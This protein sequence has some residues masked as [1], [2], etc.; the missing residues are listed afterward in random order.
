MTTYR[1]DA[2]A[3]CMIVLDEKTGRWK[4][5]RKTKDRVCAPSVM[6]DIKPFVARATEKPVEITSRSQLARYERANN[7]RQ[8]GDFKPGEVIAKR[9]KKLT[10]EIAEA[11]KRAGVPL[12]S[13]NWSEF[14]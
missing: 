9:Q 8:C 11:T 1:Y 13:V 2:D 14:R 3:K 4:K 10:T 6:A 5:A 7:V 12:S